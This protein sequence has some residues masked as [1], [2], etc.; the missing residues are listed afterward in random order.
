[1]NGHILAVAQCEDD[2]KW[3]GMRSAIIVSFAFEKRTTMLERGFDNS[4]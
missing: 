2:E 3:Y 4:V 1:M